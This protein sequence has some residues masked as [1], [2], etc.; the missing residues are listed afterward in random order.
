MTKATRESGID[1][2]IDILD[3]L[4]NHGRPMV[5]NELAAAMD[6]PRS[7]IYQV[8]KNLLNR[9]VLD[10]YSGGRVFLGRKLFLY[11]SSVSEQYSLIELSKPFID[12]LADKLGE[13]VELNGL[14]DWKQSILYVADGKRAYFLPPNP[15][16][17]YSLPLTSS[18]RFLIDGL[19]EETLATHIPEEDFFRHGTRVMTLERFMQESQE[20]K[21]RGYSVTSDL[22][23]T[24]ISSISRPIID[25]DGAVIAT[26]GLA[27][28]TGELD[29]N[30]DRFIEALKQTVDKVTEKFLIVG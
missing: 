24:H 30:K 16:A 18:G 7:T 2:A 6:A 19:D 13:R 11:G 25:A 1:R 17:S 22:L 29:A 14:V 28:P 4:H 12:E 5:I 9:S 15:S 26:I 3:C 20:A 21:M 8:T 23:D 27:F 10:S